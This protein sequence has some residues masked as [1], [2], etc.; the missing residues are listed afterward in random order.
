MMT[1]AVA[2]QEVGLAGSFP[3]PLL[4]LKGCRQAE[5]ADFVRALGEPE[6][7]AR[8]IFS[9][10]YRPFVTDFVQMSD[11]SRAFRERLPEVA[12][13]GVDFISMGAL[14]HSAVSR[15]VGLDISFTN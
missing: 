1:T 10:L 12:S 13:T 4:D 5:I 8:Q 9:W 15:D 7:R 11:L 3:P 14:T 2:N 6:F